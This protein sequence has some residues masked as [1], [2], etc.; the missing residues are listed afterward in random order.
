MRGMELEGTGKKVSS[1][2]RHQNKQNPPQKTKNPILIAPLLTIHR[3]RLVE[4][5]GVTRWRWGA[6]DKGKE[7]RKEEEEEGKKSKCR[8]KKQDGG[9]SQN[10]P[11]PNLRIIL[12]RK[13]KNFFKRP[14]RKGG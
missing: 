12:V 7:D 13:M 9:R 4:R 1:K 2:R 5:V 14:L 10:P 11:P 8:K 6:E 3:M